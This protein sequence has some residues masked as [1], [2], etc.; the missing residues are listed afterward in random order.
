MI[1]RI[2][3]IAINLSEQFPSLAND[4]V[5]GYL[6]TLL[7]HVVQEMDKQLITSSLN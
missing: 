5:H 1:E 2:I 3:N 6:I 7:P 4:F